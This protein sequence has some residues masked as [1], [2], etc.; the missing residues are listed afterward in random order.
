MTALGCALVAGAAFAMD[1]PFPIWEGEEIPP[2]ATEFSD[3]QALNPSDPDRY[4]L[5]NAPLDYRRYNEA[6]N[7]DGAGFTHMLMSLQQ[8]NDVPPGSTSFPWTLFVNLDTNHDDGDGVASHL[9]LHNRGAGWSAVAHADGFAWGTGTTLGNNIEML[10][11]NGGNA[12]TVGV[13]I[14]NKAWQGDVGLQIQTG[15]LRES[16]PLFEPGMDGSWRTGIK[17]AGHGDG[18]YYGTAVEIGPRTVGKRGI[19][20]RGDFGIGIDL[21]RNNLRMQ[22]GSVLSLD[23]KERI[24]MRFN[25]KRKRIEF[26]DKGKV[27]A[28]LDVSERNID[29]S[30]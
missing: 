28:F 22:G 1:F 24:G 26:L 3:P 7:P 23:G 18:G 5:V 11:M 30:R 27:I 13:N 9:R 2:Q 14:Q 12:H 20:L 4:A 6:P 21:G 8:Q 17:I 16:H 10:D 29:L 25:P 15:P 19:W